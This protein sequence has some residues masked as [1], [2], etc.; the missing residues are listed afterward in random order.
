[1]TTK[2]RVQNLSEIDKLM[3]IKN[4]TP[5]QVDKLRELV[6]I[7]DKESGTNHF[8]NPNVAKK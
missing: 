5:E 7:M 8:I 4:K 3:A 2:E 6:R 1:M